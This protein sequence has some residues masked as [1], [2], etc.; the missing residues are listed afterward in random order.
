M[1]WLCTACI[2]LLGAKAVAVAMYGGLDPTGGGAL[3]G[4]SWL[5]VYCEA[6]EAGVT[7]L[8]LINAVIGAGVAA[9]SSP[10]PPVFPFDTPQPVT[11]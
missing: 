9:C 6:L 4:W 10:P 5:P 7:S 11:I 2:C 8:T 3:A 1:H